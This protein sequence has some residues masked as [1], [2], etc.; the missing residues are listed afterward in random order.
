MSR[1]PCGYREIEEKEVIMSAHK[2]EC[3][4]FNFSS[5]ELK[6]LQKEDSSIVTVKQWLLK[7]V[8]PKQMDIDGESLVVKIFLA[9]YERLVSRMTSYIENGMILN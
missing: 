2:A 8:K 1:I 7:G 5:P 9:Q 4:D 3:K 6:L